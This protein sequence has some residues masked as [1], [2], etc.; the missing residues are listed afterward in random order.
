MAEQEICCQR[1]TKAEAIVYL[2]DSVTVGHLVGTVWSAPIVK[3]PCILR[4]GST[5]AF[6][7][8]HSAAA[9]AARIAWEQHSLLALS[10]AFW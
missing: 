10:H 5:A 3:P 2:A 8:R 1:R 6:D 9:W 7:T 4:Y